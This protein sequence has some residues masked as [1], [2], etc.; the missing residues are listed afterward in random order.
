[1]NR[2]KADVLVIGGGG[3][4]C[5]AAIAAYD[6]GASVLMVLKG[7]IGTSGATTYRFS[8]MAGMTVSDDLNPEDSREIFYQD[9]ISAGAGMADPEVVQTLVDNARARKDDLENWGTH[10]ERDEDGNYLKL[11]GCFAS[12]SRGYLLKDHGR[13]IVHALLNQIQQRNIQV[14]E[15]SMIL[16]LVVHDGACVGAVGLNEK[17]E[18]TLFDA[19]AVVMA[20]GGMVRI[21]KHNVNPPDITGDGYAIANRAGVKQCNLEF[22]QSGVGYM[23]PKIGAFF[24]YV[25]AG[26]PNL[27]N[28][29]GEKFLA[30]YL[31]EGITEKDVM[32]QHAHH[33]PFSTRDI[34][35]YI[36][37]AVQKEIAEG[38]GTEHGGIIID[39]KHFTPEYVSSINYDMRN[40]WPRTLE[41]YRNIG[42]DFL[43]DQ[44]E[45]AIFGHAINGGI[46][47]DKMAQSSMPG[48]Y[49]A[50]EVAAGSHG[51]DRLGGTMLLASQVF[52]KIAG[53]NAAF[54][55]KKAPAGNLDQKEAMGQADSVIE[56]LHKS[57][58]VTS[59]TAKL[60][61]S[62]SRNLLLCKSES[63]LN[64]ML[65]TLDDLE[66]EI[67]SAPVEDK[68]S[69]QSVSLANQLLSARLMTTAAKERKESRGSHY[70]ED[71][72]EI[73]PQFEHTIII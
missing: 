58:D 28:G 34:S 9:I 64:R 19:K 46:K 25:W 53:E 20:A 72:P 50:G 49:A 59:C 4:A 54:Y 61:E 2:V 21:F 32:L 26:F 6:A 18:L 67:N 40:M 33:F 11:L 7:K 1:M 23:H 10:F 63:S 14:M 48:L 22:M 45:I 68:I 51:A 36:D 73:N 24:C 27:Y 17:D 44:I 5:R 15:N 12:Q 30:N 35:K 55:A 57:L 71:Y 41:F 29:K 43:K 31:P 3:A 16:S 42:M 8:E 60:Q 13:P 69:R 38:R 47:I 56:M 37:I 52:G 65:Q 66:K 70:R 39:F 62:A